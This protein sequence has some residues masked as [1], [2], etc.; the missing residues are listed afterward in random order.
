MSGNL[1][2]MVTYP[3]E[4]NEIGAK[5]GSWTSMSAEIQI[6]AADKYKSIA[7]PNVNIGFRPVI[8]YLGGTN[9]K[10]NKKFFIPPG[11]VKVTDKFYFDKT[12]V[13]N[14][15]WREYTNWN[16]RTYGGNSN[17]YINSLPDTTVWVSGKI[18]NQ[19]YLTHYFSHPAYNNYPVVGITYEQ[20]IDFCK[21]R[22]ERVKEHITLLK[23]K[24]K[25]TYYPTNFYY[26]LPTKEEWEKIANVGY[27][28][29]T[30]KKLEG[31]YEGNL[32]VNLR[33]GDGDQMGV[34]GNL[35]DNAD[36]T[37]PVESYL[38]NALGCYNLIGNVAEMIE[39]KGIA[40]GGAWVHQEKEV[41]V[42][43][44]FTYNTKSCWLGFRCVVEILE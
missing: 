26:R 3:T 10:D 24:N 38:P 5:G 21:W 37:A 42:E 43:K 17:E 23:K 6:I 11:T 39:E 15:N 28:E 12:E 20:V 16:M 7:T 30:M 27:S 4:N 34:A 44:D 9:Y 19:P 13:S 35:Q 33:R 29:K 18:D 8:S 25:N 14:V 31:K 1:A 40:K 22:T 41:S 36:I 2:E 32:N